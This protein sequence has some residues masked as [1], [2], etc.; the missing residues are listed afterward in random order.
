MI[1]KV[2]AKRQENIE[3][4]FIFGE[5]ILQAWRNVTTPKRQNVFDS[6]KAPEQ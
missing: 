5:D 1:T 2:V 6:R 3:V 4:K